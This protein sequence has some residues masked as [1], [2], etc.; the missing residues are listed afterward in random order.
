[1]AFHDPHLNDYLDANA[2][3]RRTLRLQVETDEL[4]RKGENRLQRQSQGRLLD[5]ARSQLRAAMQ[6]LGR[7]AFRG[8]VSVEMDIDIPFGSHSPSAPKSVK[9]YLDALTGIA[10]ADDRQVGH[11]LV[12][13]FAHDHP[14]ARLSLDNQTHAH[15]PDTA[16]P[17][18]I[19]IA[20]LRLY[21]AD[22]DRVFARRDD[23]ARD[24]DVDH[25]AVAFFE[26]DDPH[27]FGR[28]ELVVLR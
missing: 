23:L 2:W 11:L 26:D 24:R 3:W 9:R 16:R 18:R 5:E 13:R 28:D 19:V 14:H 27:D 15:K 4:L 6:H 25:E 7:R 21:V 1:M 12:R 8:E 20:P 10:Y 17:V 22:Y